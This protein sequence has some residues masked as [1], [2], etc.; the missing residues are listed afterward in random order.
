MKQMI[1]LAAMGALLCSVPA[2]AINITT[3]GT[4]TNTRNYTLLHTNQLA[5]GFTMIQL[6]TPLGDGCIWAFID[7]T[8]KNALAIV[9]AA[10]AS[11]TSV[12]VTYA[13]HITSP[14]GDAPVCAVLSIE[15]S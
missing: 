10:K 9:L 3:V 11:A 5:R 15:M 8:D 13:S 1:T 7:A 14:W 2:Q 6:S 12:T 4:I